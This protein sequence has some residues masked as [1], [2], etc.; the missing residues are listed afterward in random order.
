MTEHFTFRTEVINKYDNDGDSTYEAF[1][2]SFEAM[3]ICADV[4]GDYLCMHGG[5]S[6]DLNTVADIDKINRFIEPPLTGFLCD[7]LW[8]DPCVDKEASKLKFSKN[9][10]RECSY[11]F[12]LEPVK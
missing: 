12:G 9:V 1:I 8:S 4:N 6:P 11:K 5:I 2:E 7:L 3:P 10:E